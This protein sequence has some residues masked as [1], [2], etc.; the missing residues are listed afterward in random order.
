MNLLR[1]ANM[2]H[3]GKYREKLLHLLE[4]FRA[5]IVQAPIVLPHMVVAAALYGLPPK[6]IV[7]AGNPSDPKTIELLQAI[8]STYDPHRIVLSA[9]GESHEFFHKAGLETFQAADL[10]VKGAP[11][12]YICENFTCQ[13][14]TTDVAVLLQQLGGHVNKVK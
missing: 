1:L 7:V 11:A 14:P 5:K 8:R 10:T 12:V 2:L 3:D 6:Q 13:M 9:F 4:S